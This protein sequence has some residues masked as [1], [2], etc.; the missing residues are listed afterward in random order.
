MFGFG[1]T[2]PVK[3]VSPVEASS[4]VAAGQIH[5]VDV[6]EPGEWQAGHIP[7]AINAPLSSLPDTAG[8][9][10]GDKPVVF[11]CLSG[12]RSQSAI[13]VARKL[14]LGHDTHMA[15]GISAWRAHGLPVEGGA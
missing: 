8:K 11:Y 15:G 4:L 10:P 14:G 9:L 7:G 12:A 13:G 1:R 3:T 6:R 2:P 5:L